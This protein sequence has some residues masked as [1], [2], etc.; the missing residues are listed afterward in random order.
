MSLPTPLQYATPRNA[1][2]ILARW[3]LIIPLLLVGIA[4]WLTVGRGITDW[5]RQ[6]PPL[7]CG[8]AILILMLV[9]MVRKISVES[10]R[11]LESKLQSN[12]ALAALLI[13]ILSAEPRCHIVQRG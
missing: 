4:A 6:I 12:I 13:A 8:G 3:W 2:P 10:L 9:P 5:P 1:S 7:M 11:S